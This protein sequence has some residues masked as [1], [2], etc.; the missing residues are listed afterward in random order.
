MRTLVERDREMSR[1]STAAYLAT[2]WAAAGL[3]GAPDLPSLDFPVEQVDTSLRVT[4]LVAYRRGLGLGMSPSQA[5]ENALVQ[6]SGAASRLVLEAGRETALAAV[7]NHRARWARIT[8]PTACKF[9]TMLA[10]RGFAYRSEET[11][12]FDAHDH[13]ACTAAV[14]FSAAQAAA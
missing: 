9:C 13:C 5:N 11:V 10:G 6:V 1:S 4:S 14:D 8:S 3:T 12:S 7:D 2:A